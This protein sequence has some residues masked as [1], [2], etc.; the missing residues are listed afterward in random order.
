MVRGTKGLKRRLKR[1][2]EPHQPAHPLGVDDEPFAQQFPDDA[3]VAVVAVLQGDAL[4]GV[5]Q[6]GVLAPRLVRPETAIIA[7]PRKLRDPAQMLNLV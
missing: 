7:G 4:N 5:A 6:I 2:S 3:P 1:L